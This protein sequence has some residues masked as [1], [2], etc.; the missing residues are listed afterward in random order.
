MLSMSRR[1]HGHRQRAG[2]GTRQLTGIGAGYRYRKQPSTLSGTNLDGPAPPMAVDLDAQI[3]SDKLSQ[4]KRP[5]GRREFAHP[6]TT[7]QPLR[8]HKGDTVVGHGTL[9][10]GPRKHLVIK[11]ALMFSYAND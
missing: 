7:F 5:L 10:A 1:A 8:A 4:L 9:G 11:A 3:E 2:D 6:K